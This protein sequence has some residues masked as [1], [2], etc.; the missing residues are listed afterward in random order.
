MNFK[1]YDSKI[2]N[3]M[4]ENDKKEDAS[5]FSP[6]SLKVKQYTLMFPR[7]FG[8]CFGVRN[9]LNIVSDA[10]VKNKNRKKYILSEIIHNQNVNDDLKNCNVSFIFD[11][12]GKQQISY[13]EIT[14]DDVCIIPAFG[15]TQET[16]ENLNKIIKKE[17]IYDTCCPYVKKVWEASKKIAA[18]N[19]T[20]LIHGKVNHEETKA[21][22][23]LAKREAP[24]I[25][26]KDFEEAIFL[27]EC[28]KGNIVKEKFYE[29][30][31][32][33]ISP[34]FNF[35]NDLKRIGIVNQTTMLAEETLKI[36][37]VI[38]ETLELIQGGVFLDFCSTL[39]YTTS[40]NQKSVYTLMEEK[41]DAVFVIGGFNSSNTINLYKIAK[42]FCD[43]TFFIKDE[44]S[45]I[46][47]NELL[48]FDIENKQEI[49]I[50]N[51]LQS[52]L[53]I[54]IIAGA[55]CPDILIERVIKFFKI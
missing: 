53:K 11:K 3:K 34:N 25:V 27:S 24:V 17:N 36:S 51:Y 39:C 43:K 4:R 28:I 35:E 41:L 31:K 2:L 52:A 33:V 44:K 5:D 29:K 46:S 7:Y 50:K 15:T 47:K 30:F 55:S 22:F 49:I 26:I 6:Y 42:C 40:R 37:N 48:S 8:F 45:F 19:A 21:L 1:N 23:S 10:I 32:N 16:Y 38:K 20:I 12:Y 14:C 54:G 9:A 13:K 18:K